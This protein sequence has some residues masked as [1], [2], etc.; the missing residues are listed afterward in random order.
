MDVINPGKFCV[1]LFKGFDFTGV[2]IFHF[3]PKETDVAVITVLRYRAA[4]DKQFNLCRSRASVYTNVD[5]SSYVYD[6]RRTMMPCVV[7]SGL[8]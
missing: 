8:V 6:I 2:Q 5:I 4:C 3:F 1:N 7:Q